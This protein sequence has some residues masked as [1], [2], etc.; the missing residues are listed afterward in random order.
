[1]RDVLYVAIAVAFFVA[2]AWLVR[3]G[4][5]TRPGGES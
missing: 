5:G 2:A 3:I 4:E 1:M